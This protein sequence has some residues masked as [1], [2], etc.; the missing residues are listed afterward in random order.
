[1]NCG[2]N[3]VTVDTKN[4]IV[5]IDT[6]HVVYTAS[7]QEK[8]RRLDSLFNY[9]HKVLRFN[10]AVLV[11]QKGKVLYK[12]YFGY[13]NL[14]TK[15]TLSIKSS[16][17]LA[18]VSKPF[19]STAILILKERGQLNLHDDIKKYF[20][21]FPYEGISI[22]QLLTHRSGLPNYMY[23]C[24]STCANE[25][26]TMLSNTELLNI[27]CNCKP[28]MYHKKNHHFQYIN[29]NYA[30]LASVVEKITGLS[31]AAFLKKEIFDPLDMKNTYIKDFCDTNSL[32]IETT[33]FV[34]NKEAGVDYLDGVCGDKGVYSTVEDMF[35]WDQALYTEKILKHETLN[36]AFTPQNKEQHIRNYGY[37]W[38][39]LNF[40]DGTKLV[41][42]NGWWHGYTNLFHRRIQD[43]TTIIILS[44][45]MNKS[46]YHV[47]GVYQILDGNYDNELEDEQADSTS[48]LVF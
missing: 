11:A 9:W 16:Y 5:S 43:S 15:D 3:K 39:L 21:E 37:G 48:S 13:A 34:G 23:F 42:H 45:R 30:V 6:S 41:Y 31:F 20:P 27:M 22:W 24:E 40:P 2:E 47:Q 26:D 19:T 29:T 8:G 7:E 17:Q 38:R 4:Q 32:P 14:K 36:E 10:G 33:G 44:N 28:E 35:K 25:H 12:N 18:S 46:I 1:M